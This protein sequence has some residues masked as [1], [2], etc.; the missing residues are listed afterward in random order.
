MDHGSNTSWWT[1]LISRQED[2][3]RS[4]AF[5]HVLFF[6]I[7]SP[8]RGEKV[9]FLNFLCEFDMVIEL[10]DKNDWSDHIRKSTEQARILSRCLCNAHCVSRLHYFRFKNRQ[11][12]R[13]EVA[14]SRK[15]RISSNR[16]SVEQVHVF[17]SNG[18][19]SWSNLGQ[20]LYISMLFSL[21]YSL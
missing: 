8:F 5:D 20:S 3:T 15:K 4:P 10:G 16:K 11:N 19:I 1:D 17:F 6:K 9:V 12:D 13:E 2:R 21:G 18:Q 14:L 7:C